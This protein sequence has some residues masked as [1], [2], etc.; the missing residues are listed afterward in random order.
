MSTTTRR[1]H[2][3]ALALLLASL[4]L[5]A[6]GCALE[7]GKTARAPKLFEPKPSRVEHGIASYYYGR[8]IGRKTANGEI[9]RRDDITAAHKHLPFDTV[10]RVTNKNNGK[11][12]VVRINNRGPY[13]RGRIIDLSL[14]AATK[15]DM[16]KRGIV[17]V[18]VEVL[19]P[20]AETE[21]VRDFIDHGQFAPGRETPM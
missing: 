13:I 4:G 9:Y 2:S 20:V 3:V 8:W 18:K 12:V 7:D 21:L 5:L 16:K 10:V 14:A 15:L 17:P 11:S 19:K 1:K 6:T